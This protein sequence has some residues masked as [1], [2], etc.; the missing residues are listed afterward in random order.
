MLVVLI[1][2]RFASTRFPGKP[3]ID[4][5]GIT[6]IRRVYAQAC[7][8]TLPG[9]VAVATDDARIYDHVLESGG[10]AVMTDAQHQS[11]TDRC[12]EAVQHF[13]EATHVINVQGDEPFVR[14]EQIDQ[15][16]ALLLREASADIATL[17]KP[18]HDPA[19]LHNPNTV[20]AVLDA[21]K[22]ALYFSRHPIPYL[23][24]QS[25]DTWLQQHAY[26]KHLGMYGYRR[27]V[28]QEIAAL[29]PS[30]LEQAESL[31]QLRWLEAGYRI[32]T[33]LTH[34]ETVSIDT[35]QDVEKA[36]AWYRQ[37]GL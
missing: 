23:R 1:P 26:L 24:G 18:L 13:P 12:A 22:R 19:E 31:E 15:L 36:L 5:D 32:H 30:P 25:P 35:P 8:A 33:A 14:H 10:R 9:A 21:Q 3:L 6:M 20:K 11:G 4:L 29:P 28:L 16:A 2:A 17:V 34:F 37:S 7:R 27:P